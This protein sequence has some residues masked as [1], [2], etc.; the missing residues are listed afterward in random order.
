MFSIFMKNLNNFKISEEK[1]GLSSNEV[2]LRNVEPSTLLNF[3]NDK[4]E[5]LRF[6]E[7]N[8]K[9]IGINKLFKK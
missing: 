7:L 1:I 4:A 9:K 5:L 3:A 2:S 8:N 6:G